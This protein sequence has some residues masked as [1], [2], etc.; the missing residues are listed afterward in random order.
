MFE[1]WVVVLRTEKNGIK[2]TLKTF[3]CNQTYLTLPGK[4]QVGD[5]VPRQERLVG[6]GTRRVHAL[7]ASFW[8]ADLASWPRCL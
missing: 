4:E 1:S 6:W 2:Y 7:R 5:G 3:I 8:A